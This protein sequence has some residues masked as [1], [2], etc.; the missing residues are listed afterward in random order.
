VKIAISK[1]AVE[2]VHR[3]M[4]E[5]EA[6]WTIVIRWDSGPADNWRGAD[7]STVWS[8][9][10]KGLWAVALCHHPKELI[11][12]E[13]WDK[14]GEPLLPGVRVLANSGFPG[15]IIDVQDDRLTL[16]ATAV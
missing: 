15:G 1:S 7:G 9:P 8:R 11:P 13:F 10:A 6:L 12:T 4:R 14:L 2:F 16:Q 5:Q 3:R